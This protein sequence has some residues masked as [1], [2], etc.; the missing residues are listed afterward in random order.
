MSALYIMRYVGQA[1]GQAGMGGGAL[2]V[3]KGIISGV[4]VG[5][6]TYDGSYKEEAGRVKGAAI[7]TIG[8]NGQLVTGKVLPQGTK[9]PLQIDWPADF[10]DGRAQVVSVQGHPVHVTFEKLRDIP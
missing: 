7:M 6:G 1:G 5:L 4:D 10:A 3:G 8:L 2:Y 9:V